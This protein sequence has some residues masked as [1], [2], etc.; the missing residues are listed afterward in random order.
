MNL[1]KN[2]AAREAL[3]FGVAIVAAFVFYQLLAFGLGTSM[4]LVAVVSDSMEPTLHVGDLILVHMPDEYN[5]GDIA[6]YNRG[7]ITI[8]HR[9]IDITPQGYV[10]QGD[11][12]PAPDPEIVAPD[13][14]LGRG[15]FAI[16]L[17]GYPR[18]VLFALGI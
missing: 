13:R 16:P 9:I 14:L 6:I 15:R 5:V 3:E 1:K 12:N 8:I 18:L 10:F 2:K 7:S 17:L 11:N 4:P